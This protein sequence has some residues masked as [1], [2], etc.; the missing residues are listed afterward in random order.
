MTWK[1]KFIH[2]LKVIW[3]SFFFQVGPSAEWSVFSGY[4]NNTSAGGNVR[5]KAENEQE[6]HKAQPGA[7]PSRGELN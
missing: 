6:Q 4:E 7:R 5:M 1:S 3:K 2:P